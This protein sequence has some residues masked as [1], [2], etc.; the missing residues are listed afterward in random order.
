[1]L[2]CSRQPIISSSFASGETAEGVV[3]GAVKGEGGEV[4]G[5][6]YNEKSSFS[7]GGW[8]EGSGRASTAAGSTGS[9][10]KKVPTAILSSRLG[11]SPEEPVVMTTR[12]LYPLQ[13]AVTVENREDLVLH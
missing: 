1:L 4:G 5:I 7:V 10:G 6:G 9:R 12:R 11:R 13:A 2:L 8:G 3:G